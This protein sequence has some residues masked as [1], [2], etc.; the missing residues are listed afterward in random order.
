MQPK[1]VT[2]GQIPPE[3]IL[4]AHHQREQAAKGVGTLPG[5][6]IQNPGAAAARIDQTGE[7]FERGRLAGAVG[8]QKGHHF[9]RLNREADAVD[10]AYFFV[11][12]TVKPAQRA[13]EA[14][15]LLADA[16]SFGE[17]DGLNDRHGKPVLENQGTS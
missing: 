14:F 1:T 16:I 17:I 4:L 7:H 2:G 15:L 3:L 5:S 11:L 6:E 10:G 13:K 9:S 8:S 12:A